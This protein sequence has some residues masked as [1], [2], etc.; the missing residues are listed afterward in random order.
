MSLRVRTDRRLLLAGSPGERFVLA[1]LTAPPAP[2]RAG[3]E[4]VNLAF[5]LDRSGSMHGEKIELAR[6][7]IG[8][9]LA[10]IRAQ[11]PALGEHLDAA[12][13]TGTSCAYRPRDRSSI[14]W[15]L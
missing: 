14:R 10:R 11:H 6:R 9:A 7:A 12:I 13:R 8:A 1:E 4:P 15:T 2:A 5:V 3:R